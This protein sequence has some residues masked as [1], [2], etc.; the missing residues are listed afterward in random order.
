LVHPCAVLIVVAP[1]PGS[2]E[3]LHAAAVGK[4]VTVAV[5]LKPGAVH[6]HPVHVPAIRLFMIVVMSV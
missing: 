3:L 6:E 5:Q 4:A 2:D 1:T